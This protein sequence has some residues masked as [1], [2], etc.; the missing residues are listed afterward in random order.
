MTL[1][2][3]V[4]AVKQEKAELDR[5]ESI[6]KFDKEQL[7][8]TSTVEKNPLPDPQGICYGPNLTCDIRPVV[9][10]V[11][12]GVLCYRNKI[13]QNI[14]ISTKFSYF[15]GI[16]CPSSFAD[17]DQLWQE[18][19]DPPFGSTLTYMKP[20]Q[21]MPFHCIFGLTGAVLAFPF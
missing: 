17:L 21:C 6:E 20:T 8:K 3:V 13:S 10:F 15:V 19:A 14:A 16:L 18:T 2:L 12:I 4:V 7:K 9:N 1:R 5:R 11:W